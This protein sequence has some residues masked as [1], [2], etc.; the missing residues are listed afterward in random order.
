MG[1]GL[2]IPDSDNRDKVE[3]WQVTSV[4]TSRQGWL[5]HTSHRQGRCAS[6]ELQAIRSGLHMSG[7][8]TTE[9]CENLGIKRPG[10]SN[11]RLKSSN[12]QVW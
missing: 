4:T 3:A 6:V 5:S 11:R 2:S 10:A 8:A 1:G 9:W 12:V 7:M